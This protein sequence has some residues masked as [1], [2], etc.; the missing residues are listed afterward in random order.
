MVYIV[1]YTIEA[2]GHVS[3]QRDAD[4]WSWSNEDGVLIQFLMKYRIPERQALST[5]LDALT[6]GN[7]GWLRPVAD[8]AGDWEFDLDGFKNEFGDEAFEPWEWF[9]GLVS[10]MPVYAELAPT[11]TT[12]TFNC[13]RQSQSVTQ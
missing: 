1:T 8:L 9:S 4:P 7:I 3:P 11:F 10:I 12:I 2:S 6:S 13:L 5:A